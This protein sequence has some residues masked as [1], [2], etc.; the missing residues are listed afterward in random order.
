MLNRIVDV[1]NPFEFLKDAVMNN[2][3]WYGSGYV[4]LAAVRKDGRMYL[5]LADVGILHRKESPV[6]EVIRDYRS[7]VLATIPV[8]M[9]ELTEIVDE[10]RSGHID[11]G[12]LKDID[13]GGSFEDQAYHVPGGSGFMGFHNEWPSLGLRYSLEERGPF[14]SML[15]PLVGPGLPVYPSLHEAIRTFFNHES[16]PPQYSPICINFTIP[17][18]RARIKSLEIAEKRIEVLAEGLESAMED[19]TVKIY[20]AKG[21]D[22]SH[23]SDDLHPDPSGRVREDLEFV[24]DQVYACLF[25]LKNNTMIDSKAFGTQYGGQNSGVTVRTP[26]EAIESMIAGGEGLHVEFKRDLGKADEFLE[27]VVAFSNTVGG[28]ILLGVDDEGSPIGHS[29]DFGR[30]KERILGLISGR[31]EPDIRA[32]IE[33]IWSEGVPVVVVKVEEGENKPYLLRDRPAYKRVGDRDIAFKRIDFDAAYSK[34]PNTNSAVIGSGK[35]ASG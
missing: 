32:S 35:T 16:H 19:I 27:S 11:V 33:E 2:S 1:P 30:V 10:L 15:D 34:K 31:C 14:G 12:A 4:R 28:R 18:F 6:R 17:D 22:T 21:H 23:N 24:P 8:G 9:H 20:C 7:V 25:D 13:A 29:G 3:D 5:W 26:V